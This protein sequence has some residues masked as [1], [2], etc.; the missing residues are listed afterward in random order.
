MG[1]TG[2]GWERQK[3][4][5]DWTGSGIGNERE[6]RFDRYLKTVFVIIKNVGKE[7]P[8]WFQVLAWVTAGQ[9]RPWD[10]EQ[11]RGKKWWEDNKLNLVPAER[12]GV[13]SNS[14]LVD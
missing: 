10:K 5:H 3:I 2:S 11:Q 4:K 14:M 13:F 1:K 6:N 9:S 12:F 8:G 7:D